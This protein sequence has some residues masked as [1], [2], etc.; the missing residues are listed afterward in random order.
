MAVAKNLCQL[1]YGNSDTEFHENLCL[2]QSYNKK[3]LSFHFSRNCSQ[4]NDVVTNF[5]EFVG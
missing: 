3:I 2:A 1:Y 5:S 4:G